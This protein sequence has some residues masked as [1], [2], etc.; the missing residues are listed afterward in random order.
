ME[1][2]KAGIEGQGGVVRLIVTFFS[3]VSVYLIVWLVIDP[4][5]YFQ[6]QQP[7][8]FVD[9][10]FFQNHAN[11]P[12]GLLDYA[13]AY[14]SQA[15]YFS[16]LGAL[17]VTLCL[18]LIALVTR[19]FIKSINP[20]FNSL[21]L[22]WIPVFLL[23]GLHFNYE[24]TLSIS[25]GLLLALL[26]FNL[27]E[28]LKFK[29]LFIHTIAYLIISVIL[30]YIAAGAF[31]LF[32]LLVLLAGILIHKKFLMALPVIISL[33]IP[34]IAIKYYFI[35]PLD[36]ACFHNLP[37]SITY[38]PFI[39]PY[40][41]VFLFPT[42]ILLFSL[43]R[44]S[45]AST[46]IEKINTSLKPAI[47]LGIS[48]ILSIILVALIIF[49]A[50]DSISKKLLQVDYFAREEMWDDL[51]KT[52]DDSIIRNKFVAFETNR[53]LA[54]TNQLSS[55][56]FH[57]TRTSNPECLFLSEELGFNEPLKLS[58]FYYNLGHMNAAQ[59]WANEAIA[60]HGFSPFIFKRL[61]LI[62][63]IKGETEVAQKC[64]RLLKKTILF[65]DW[66]EEHMTLLAKDGNELSSNIELRMLKTLIPK[67]DFVCRI[68]HPQLDLV[69]LLNSNPRNKKAFEY[70]NAYYLLT[71]QLDKFV[72]N[73]KFLPFYQY[74]NIP[75]HYEEALLIYLSQTKDKNFKL[76]GY[77]ISQDTMQDFKE[78]QE[79]RKNNRNNQSIARS[80]INRRLGGTYWE[81]VLF[82]PRTG[83]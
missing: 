49:T 39:L 15:F 70:L 46:L 68:N 13:A 76:P 30:F 59:H 8:F 71:R 28:N 16:W 63:I 33:A 80:E 40:I 4:V 34:Y 75:K 19:G 65:D 67:K 24:H 22:H 52:V 11:Y 6:K 77:K 29:N 48:S 17:V 81:Y 7:V 50:F 73:L 72:N 57:F 58:N 14:F 62:H 82:I 55:K 43:N 41:L 23:L 83:S 38:K 32:A 27:L 1:K 35:Y 12:G 18:G 47:R 53:A 3:L 36:E 26:S 64:L 5:L 61:A 44:F 37:F 56:L 51:L 78:I 42:I 45:W 79:I 2:N 20:E 66:A 25:L 74:S 9:S 60:Q 54:E 21:I 69:E 10:L 31:L